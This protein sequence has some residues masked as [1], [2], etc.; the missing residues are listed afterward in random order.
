MTKKLSRIKQMLN[1]NID[2]QHGNF[3][4]TPAF[5]KYLLAICL[6]NR[7]ARNNVEE[8]PLDVY[9]MWWYRPGGGRYGAYPH[10]ILLDILIGAMLVIL[11]P[12]FAYTTVGQSSF[13]LQQVPSVA[14]LALIWLMALYFTSIET[15]AV[16]QL[17]TMVN[18]GCFDQGFPKRIEFN[19][20]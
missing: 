12:V 2:I 17:W 9:L 6:Y 15:V 4:H 1:R 16:R 7:A 3:Q 10:V 11:I 13:G 5:V 14:V 19:Q 20:D 18:K 8:S